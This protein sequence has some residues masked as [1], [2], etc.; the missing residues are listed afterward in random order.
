MGRMGGVI[1]M[2]LGGGDGALAGSEEIG[3]LADGV[4]S[5]ISTRS[6]FGCSE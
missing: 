2:G 5:I 3:L 6:I 4:I 1:V